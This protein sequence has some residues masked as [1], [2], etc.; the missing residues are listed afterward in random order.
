MGRQLPGCTGCPLLSFSQVPG[1]ARGRWL[2]AGTRRWRLLQTKGLAEVV[3]TDS[4]LV[5]F[6]CHVKKVLSA[7]L[8]SVFLFLSLVSPIS[9]DNLELT[10]SAAGGPLRGLSY[11]SCQQPVFPCLPG[12]AFKCMIFPVATARHEK[13]LPAA[14][15]GALLLLCHCRCWPLWPL[16]LL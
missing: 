7:V 10:S 4:F 3:R 12:P 15:T 13:V 5:L 2:V 9:D 11:L 8:P 16:V 6:Y 1:S 14:L